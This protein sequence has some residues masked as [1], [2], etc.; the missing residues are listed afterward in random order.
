MT[1]IICG[2]PIQSPASF[3]RF[4]LPFAYQL[5][6]A[7]PSSGPFYI[8][9]AHRLPEKRWRKNYLTEET[10]EV[11]YK[12][13]KW[14]ELH[15]GTLTFNFGPRNIPITLNPS[16]V[17]FECGKTEDRSRSDI[18]Q[19]GL[20]LV[21]ATFSSTKPPNF[22]ELL[23]FNEM[24][25]YW[26][27]PFDI[28][29]TKGDAKSYRELLGKMPLD[30]ACGKR[31]LKDERDDDAIYFDHW[32]HLLRCQLEIS[33]E[34]FSLMPPEWLTQARHRA[35]GEDGSPGWVIH[36]DNRAFVWTCAIVNGGIKVFKQCLNKE[37][38]EVAEWTRLLNVDQPDFLVAHFHTEWTKPLTYTRWEGYGTV[39]GFTS[40]S[41]AM[42][43][44]ACEEPPICQHFSLMYFDQ[45]L[46]LLYLRTT[47]FRFSRE[48]HR[49]STDAK[50]DGFHKG[51][52]ELQEDFKQLRWQFVLFTNLYQFPQLSNQQQ[53]VEMYRYAREAMDVEKM[54]SEVEKEIHTTDEY[55][56]AVSEQIQSETG[57]LLS[58]VATLGLPV[59]VVIALLGIDDNYVRFI[60]GNQLWPII[61]FITFAL[62]V[63]FVYRSNHFRNLLKKFA[64]EGRKNIE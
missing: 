32:D 24:F 39:Y 55:L 38:K 46:L 27:C 8:D 26:Q 57:T 51:P 41:G 15:N 40:H 30:W 52:E 29:P 44:D 17:L 23:Q 61:I 53:A 16:L 42:L 18:F 34:R 58:V 9:I 10:A 36:A 7:V 12:Q 14:F 31:L 13:A 62:F 20:L 35:K 6:P 19:T 33:G 28:H 59:A 11:L 60:E 64:D 2:N 1:E 4:V 21:D 22:D 5:K 54:F 50:A 63:L 48:L 25:R 37:A 45:V 3:T 56:S 49:I 43:A 47:I